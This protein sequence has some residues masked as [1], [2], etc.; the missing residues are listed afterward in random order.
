MHQK[1]YFH[2]KTFKRSDNQKICQLG[3]FWRKSLDEETYFKINIYT[4][5]SKR[6]VAKEL[7]NTKSAKPVRFFYY[8]LRNYGNSPQVTIYQLSKCYKNL[9][10]SKMDVSCNLRQECSSEK[11]DSNFELLLDRT[12]SRKVS[13]LTSVSF[14]RLFPNSLRVAPEVISK[15]YFPPLHVTEISWDFCRCSI[16]CCTK[17]ESIDKNNFCQDD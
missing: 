17:T 14:C 5:T 6:R 13:A 4:Y 12:I 11:G 10:T 2:T 8:I 16:V 1:L 15:T 3:S 7:I 9:G